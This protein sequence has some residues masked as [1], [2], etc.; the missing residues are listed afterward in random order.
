MESVGPRKEPKLLDSPTA[1]SLCGQ[2]KRG[3]PMPDAQ[4]GARGDRSSR[5]RYKKKVPAGPTAVS[6]GVHQG[7]SAEDPAL[8]LDLVRHA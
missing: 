2:Y 8:Q 7:G 3:R 4:K 5:R 6:V 1:D